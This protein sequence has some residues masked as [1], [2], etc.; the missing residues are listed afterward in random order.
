MSE[1][2]QAHSDDNILAAI[3]HFFGTMVAIII[4]AVQKD[5]SEYVRFQALQAV[6]YNIAVS[7]ITLILFGLIFAF[8]FKVVSIQTGGIESPD[9]FFVFLLTIISSPW[10]ACLI[11]PYVLVIYIARL[12]AVI[13]VLQGKDFRYPWLGEY[14]EKMLSAE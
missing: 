13:S 5:K 11:F 4:W 7:I 12:I 3:G 6:G 10:I 8:I 1:I 2:R 9:F 14:V